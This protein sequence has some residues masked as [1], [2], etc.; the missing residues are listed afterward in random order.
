MQRIPVKLSGAV[1]VRYT[2]YPL[3]RG[4]IKMHE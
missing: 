3:T 1:G 4:A 2:S